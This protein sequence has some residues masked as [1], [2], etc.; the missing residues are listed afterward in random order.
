MNVTTVSLE[1]AKRLADTAPWLD[2]CAETVQPRVRSALVSRPWLH[3]ALGGT[4]LGAPL[5][6]ALTDVPV[7]AWTAA[8]GIDLVSTRANRAR[9]CCGSTPA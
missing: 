9:S 3:D 1:F 7:G 5:H 6:P 8:F 2:R 4:W